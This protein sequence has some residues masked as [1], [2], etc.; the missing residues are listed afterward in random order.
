MCERVKWEQQ[1]RDRNYGGEPARNR[2]WWIQ[3]LN[4]K[5]HSRPRWTEESVSKDRVFNTNGFKEQKGKMTMKTVWGTCRSLKWTGT[6]ISY[7][8]GIIQSTKVI[9]H[10]TPWTCSVRSSRGPGCGSVEAVLFSSHKA[11]VWPSARLD[12]VQWHTLLL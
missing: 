7:K 4:G 3:N 10:S 8:S 2:N 6:L 11:W 1:Q 12:Q 5:L 9:T